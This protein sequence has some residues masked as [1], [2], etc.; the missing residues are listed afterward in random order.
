M[1][2]IFEGQPHQN[3]AEIPIKTRVIWVLGIKG[4][5]V[6]NLRLATSFEKKSRHSS[7]VWEIERWFTRDSICGWCSNFACA[8]ITRWSCKTCCSNKSQIQNTGSTCKTWCFLLRLCFLPMSTSKLPNDPADLF[9][10]V[11]LLTWRHASIHGNLGVHPMPPPQ[12]N[13]ALLR[14]V[15]KKNV[16][17]N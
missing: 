5:L 4:H 12:G 7:W 2:S 17:L 6:S 15:F 1:T 11:N 10:Y 13:K 16:P 3:K 9:P 8:S 14:E